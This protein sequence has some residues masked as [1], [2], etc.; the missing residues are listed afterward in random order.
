MRECL[1]LLYEASRT[2]PLATLQPDI[3]F[4][5]TLG[6]SAPTQVDA[7]AAKAAAINLV[8]KRRGTLDAYMPVSEP[9]L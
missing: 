8:T 6:L 2:F 1:R 7:A 4:H 5:D 9:L 3:A